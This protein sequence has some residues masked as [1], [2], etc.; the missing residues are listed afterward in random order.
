VVGI[1]TPPQS[2]LPAFFVRSWMSGSQPTMNIEVGRV[3][4]LGGARAQVC[5]LF[6]LG[7]QAGQPVFAG[8][9][10]SE[11][12]AHGAARKSKRISLGRR[13]NASPMVPV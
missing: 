9:D 8:T 3:T 11:L 2:D 10:E 7:A 5:A 4:C 13:Y 6:F 1:I 12:L